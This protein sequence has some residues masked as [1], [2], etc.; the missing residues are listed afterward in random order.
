MVVGYK[1]VTKP[2]KIKYT[3]FTILEP[4]CMQKVVGLIPIPAYSPIFY[5]WVFAVQEAVYVV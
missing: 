3:D 2:S 4:P 5:V 1:E